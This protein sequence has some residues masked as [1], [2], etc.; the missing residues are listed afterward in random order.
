MR[1][2]ATA[3]HRVQTHLHAAPFPTL[4]EVAMFSSR[5]TCSA[6]GPADTTRQNMKLC[7]TCEDVLFCI[8]RAHR[9]RLLLEV[10]CGALPQ[11]EPPTHEAFGNHLQPR[12][13]PQ[14]AGV[15]LVQ[16]VPAASQ[17]RANMYGLLF[18][19]F[20]LCMPSG[21]HVPPGRRHL[22]LEHA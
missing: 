14:Q 12:D 9:R 15:L 4:M 5:S 8:H 3:M 22:C 19:S 18:F 16:G 13:V 20:F 1:G 2:A 10:L 17:H 21:M 7:M 6:T 11:Q